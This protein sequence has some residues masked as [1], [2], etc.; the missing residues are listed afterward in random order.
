MTTVA[1]LP[2]AKEIARKVLGSRLAACVQM[3]PVESAYRWHGEVLEEAE[4]LILLKT[5]EELYEELERTIAAIHPYETPEIVM[6]E[7]PHALPAYL[8]WLERETS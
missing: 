3:L 5:R 2:D 1:T 6:L 4:I 8:T 7:V